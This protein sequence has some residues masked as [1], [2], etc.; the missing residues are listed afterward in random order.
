MRKSVISVG[1]AAA[2]LIA[3][4]PASAAVNWAFTPDGSVNDLTGYSIFN[5]FET[6]TGI[7]GSGY[8]IK[9]AITDGEGAVLPNG[10]GSNYLSVLGEG[11]ASIA[12]GPGVSDFAFEWGSLDDYNTLTVFLE[13]GDSLTLVPGVDFFNPANGDQFE[14][15]TNGLF[16]VWGDAGEIFT[17]I[18]LESSSNSFEVDNLVV[19]S[20]IPE[21]ATWAM[22][23]GGLALVGASM[24]RRKVAVSF[25]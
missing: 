24:R 22:M 4:V 3:A 13:G 6:D 8:Q 1:I 15:D 17:S 9:P 2:A 12:F 10:D 18:L 7:T 11:S 16:R 5:A 20:A 14:P 25:V 23:I 19:N 21:P